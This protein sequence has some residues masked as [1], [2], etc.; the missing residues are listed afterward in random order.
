MDA[1][2]VCLITGASMGIGAEL[3]WLF[4]ERGYG[5]VLVARSQD[6]LAALAEDIRKARSVRVEVIVADLADPLAP[7]RIHEE[8]ERLGLVVDVLVNN[9]GFGTSGDFHRLPRARELEMV[10]VNVTSLVGLTQLF[11]PGMVTRGRGR[12]LNMASTAAFEPGP[13]MST[14]YASKAFVLSFSEGLAEELRGSGVSVTCECPGPVATEFLKTAGNGELFFFRTFVADA[15]S[16]ARHAI[17]ATLRGRAVAIPG[18]WNKL[19]A[20]LVRLGPRWLTRR[21]LG[22]LNRYK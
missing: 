1:A 14:Y 17:E 6:K 20:L 11:L 19:G 10:Q 21:V 5:L 22:F 4:A 7:E 12:I 15:K 9:A 13:F 2:G 8:V 18:F 16:V 3:A